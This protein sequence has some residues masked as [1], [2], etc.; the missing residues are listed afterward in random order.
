MKL[1]IHE[2]VFGNVTDGVSKDLAKSFTNK[3]NSTGLVGVSE[4]R[5]NFKVLSASVSTG[6][7]VKNLPASLDDVKLKTRKFWF[8]S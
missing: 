7:K 6:K 8:S 1:F 3:K 2:T 4:K 5:R